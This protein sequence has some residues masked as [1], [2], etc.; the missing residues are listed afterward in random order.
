MTPPPSPVGEIM[1][2]DD[3]GP[4]RK[5]TS[6]RGAHSVS[7]RGISPRRVRHLGTRSSVLVRKIRSLF[8]YAQV[9]GNDAFSDKN[10]TLG[11]TR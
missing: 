3:E 4:S 11:A 1:S 8:N 10:R 7:A 9:G 2:I 5:D 6:K